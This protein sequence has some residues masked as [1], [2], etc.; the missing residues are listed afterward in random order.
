[1]NRT[2]QIP[3]NGCTETRRIGLADFYPWAGIIGIA[4]YIFV[5]CFLE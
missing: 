2:Q 1:M 5:A 3:A 4:T